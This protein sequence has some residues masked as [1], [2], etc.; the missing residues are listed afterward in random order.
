MDRRMR[1]L[2]ALWLLDCKAAAQE[3]RVLVKRSSLSGSQCCDVLTAALATVNFLEQALCADQLD[4]HKTQN[5]PEIFAEACSTIELAQS[6]V[7]VGVSFGGYYQ[8][9]HVYPG[10]RVQIASSKTYLRG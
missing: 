4:T 7:Q 1:D 2:Y 10:I 5:L 6:V 8:A 3:L 9:A